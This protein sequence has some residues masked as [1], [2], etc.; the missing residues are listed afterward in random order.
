MDRK[1]SLVSTVLS[2]DMLCSMGSNRLLPELIMLAIDL[3]YSTGERRVRYFP[4]TF[5]LQ[6]FR[7]GC[8]PLAVRKGTAEQKRDR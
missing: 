6:E 8:P 7:G 1:S 2:L 4:T 5:P 3:V